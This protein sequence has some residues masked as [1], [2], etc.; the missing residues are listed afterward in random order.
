MLESTVEP[1]VAGLLTQPDMNRPGISGNSITT[2]VTAFLLMNTETLTGLNL[3]GAG[4]PKLFRLRLFER[5]R[6]EREPQRCS[7]R[8]RRDAELNAAVSSGVG[9]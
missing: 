1:P 5:K 4:L 8:S 2:Q 9:M 6:R 7:T 3:F